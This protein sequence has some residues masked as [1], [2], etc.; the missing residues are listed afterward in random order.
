MWI[1]LAS[2][3]IVNTDEKTVVVRKSPG[4]TPVHANRERIAVGAPVSF[5]VDMERG[6]AASRIVVWNGFGPNHHKIYDERIMAVTRTLENRG[7]NQQMVKLEDPTQ[8]LQIQYADQ[9][10]VIP[11]GVPQLIQL[12]EPRKSIDMICGTQRKTVS[13]A[14][15]FT[16]V[17]AFRSYGN[18]G[19]L[20][21]VD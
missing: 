8:Q 13:A 2:G 15:E 20:L 14:K 3:S 16:A 17:V 7:L 4:G 11:P 5:E 6:A 21:L 1:E 19:M 9:V 10:Q 12:D 18:L